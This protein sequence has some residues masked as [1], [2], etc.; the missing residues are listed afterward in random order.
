[1]CG[2]V[3]NINL[4]GRPNSEVLNLSHTFNFRGPDELSEMHSS[5]SILSFARLSIVDIEH[6]SQPTS[7][8]PGVFGVGNGEIYN[9][10][11]LRSRLPENAKFKYVGSDIQVAL[12]F[13]SIFGIE[14]VI[15][16]EG[17]FSLLLINENEKKVYLFRDRT[18]EKP[19]FYKVT[20]REITVASMQSSLVSASDCNQLMQNSISTWCHYGLLPIGQ[21]LFKDIYEVKP[22]VF[23]E[24]NET[25]IIETRYWVW[26]NRGNRRFDTT[27]SGELDLILNEAAK[28]FIQAEVPLAVALSSGLDSNT[29]NSYVRNHQV[30]RI[31]TFTLGFESQNFDESKFILT[32]ETL[33]R[34]SQHKISFDNINYQFLSNHINE[35]MDGPISD[36]GVIAFAA[37]CSE[38]SHTHRVILTGDGADELLRGYTVFKYYTFAKYTM[39]ALQIVNAPIKRAIIA[40]MLNV[41]DREYL[42][43]KQLLLRL[44]IGSLQR[45]EYRFAIALSNTFLH[46]YFLPN[47]LEEKF[48][49]MT[50]MDLEKYFQEQNL[51][52]VY[53]QKSD[54]SSM[55]FGIEARSFFLQ[56]KIINQLMGLRA[57]HAT[58]NRL[59]RFL[60]SY[61]RISELP[62][63]KHG[64]GVP[65]TEFMATLAEPEW[66]TDLMGLNAKLCEKV[67][68]NRS[69]NPA[70]ANLAW[71][72]LVLNSRVIHWSKL[73]TI[74]IAGLER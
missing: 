70:Y 44:L 7:L 43:K 31:D 5:N 71:A 36:P 42:G 60:M 66:Q 49:I 53:L 74:C 28:D 6:G 21:T 45:P 18:G 29:M 41:K 8:E 58:K 59:R 54:R 57:G 20:G 32:D 9:F 19:L 55:A 67:W 62:R 23:I 38:V 2:F 52:Q 34:D 69:L 40:L 46:S 51:P 39:Q 72:Y 33:H 50:K 17:M 16:F 27:F 10:R 22:G 63:K 12:E 25:K 61:S 15:E 3:A 65:M 13:L 68:E 56:P 64:L 1:M 4:L 47:M 14:K 30:D 37:I 35:F 11:D 48:K 24:F 73:G 26:P